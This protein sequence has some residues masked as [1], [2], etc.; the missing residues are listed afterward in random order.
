MEYR[1]KIVNDEIVEVSYDMNGK[2]T[3]TPTGVKAFY[4]KKEICD[5]YHW[6]KTLMQQNL[7]CIAKEI[8]SHNRCGFITTKKVFSPAEMTFIINYFGLP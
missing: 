5:R 1:Y 7:M 4:T 8:Y 6:G 3:E 2:A